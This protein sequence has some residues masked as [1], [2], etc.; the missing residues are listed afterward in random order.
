M[1]AQNLFCNEN[2]ILHFLYTGLFD[3]FIFI[4]FAGDYVQRIIQLAKILDHDFLRRM[5]MIE[6]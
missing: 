5:H 4:F 3:I 6:N 1:P 2:F